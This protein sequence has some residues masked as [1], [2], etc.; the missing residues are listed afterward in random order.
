M[1]LAATNPLAQFFFLKRVQFEDLVPHNHL[2]RKK[3]DADIDSEYI[4][5]CYRGVRS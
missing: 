5:E 1:E 2:A 3:V 4:C